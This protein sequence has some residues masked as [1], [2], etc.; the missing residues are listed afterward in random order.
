MRTVPNSGDLAG[1][2]GS[3]FPLLVTLSLLVV[4]LALAL[5]ASDILLIG[6][7]NVVFEDAS[8]E[9]GHDRAVIVI[10]LVV[11]ENALLVQ[12]VVIG[13]KPHFQTVLDVLQDNDVGAIG[14]EGRVEVAGDAGDVS[15]AVLSV[16]L[17]NAP[18][19]QGSFGDMLAVP[20]PDFKEGP[21]G[22]GL[23]ILWRI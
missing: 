9:T 2:A 11:M 4:R 1:A 5:P 15:E 21:E 7:K 17:D 10:V 16:F 19:G 14:V 6:R 12:G 18:F 20:E 3:I 23:H 13:V 22:I 8:L